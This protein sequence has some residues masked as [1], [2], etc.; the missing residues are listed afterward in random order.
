M[1]RLLLF[2]PCQIGSIDS[3]TN[4]LSLINVIEGF[5]SPKFPG[6]LPQF[7]LV[8]VWRRYEEEAEASMIQKIVMLDPNKEQAAT[9]ET[10]FIFE[11]LGHRVINRV[12]GLPIKSP[13]T[14]EFSIFVARQGTPFLD[15]PA[16]SYPIIVQKASSVQ[17]R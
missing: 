1:P 7:A 13:G 16:A 17:V 14:Y 3:G 4:T 2:A 5:D 15:E 8:A 12:A 9:I 10:P 11:K 6:N